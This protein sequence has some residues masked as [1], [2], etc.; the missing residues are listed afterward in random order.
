MWI[1]GYLYNNNGMGTWCWEAAHALAAAGEPVTLVC[2]PTVMLPGP[3]TIPVL[4]VAAPAQSRSA[5][6]R[7]FSPGGMLS[8][9]GARVMR[10]AV[11][12]LADQGT[13]ATRLLLNSTEFHDSEIPLPQFVT[14]WARGVRLHEYLGRLR[15]HHRGF[16]RETVRAFLGTIGW[17]RRDWYG[18]RHADAVLSVTSPLHDELRA[19]GIHS[20]LLHPCTHAPDASVPLR[21]G[22][23]VVR[24]V[25]SAASL[26]DPRKRV[27]WMLDALR[28]WR[29]TGC[30]LTLIGAPSDAVRGAASRL[31]MPVEFAGTLSRD[32]AVLAMRSCDVFLFASALDDWGYVITEAMSQGL[33][34]IAPAIAPFDE[35][36][37]ATGA[38]YVM[39]EPGAF[40][41]A[42]DDLLPRF[43]S[44]RQASWQ[45][46]HDRFSRAVF[47]QRLEWIATRCVDA[48]TPGEP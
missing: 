46:A 18:F 37:D 22:D 30:T 23:P 41:Q 2:S 3:T 11:R 1:V 8:A 45:S 4:R 33:A 38:L 25:T 12:C 43:M 48:K 36:L 26:D 28:D 42:L 35:I 32:D 34:V 17:W 7:M 40:R 44:A 19:L 9:H 24:L 27:L 15:I 39:N 20:E 5:I 13:P 31:E 14:A 6:V 10:D 16:S 21:V 29:G 47:V